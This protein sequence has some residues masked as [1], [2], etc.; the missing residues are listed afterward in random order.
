MRWASR[1]AIRL[2]LVLALITLFTAKPGDAAL[3][4]PKPG[5]AHA[6]YL[7]SHGWHSGLVLPRAVL[8]GAGAGAA[9][10]AV[11]D[12]FRTF[13]MIEFGWGEAEFY[14]ATPTVADLDWGLALKALF[15]PG[16]RAGVVQVVGL[17]AQLRAAFP[18]S[19]IVPL[20][21]S[22]EG[23]ARLLARLDAS[24][25]LADHQPVDAGPS[26]YGTGRFFAANGRF[27]FWNL[28]NHWAADLLNAA[29]L[30][31]APVLATLPRGLIL[32]LGWRSGAAALPLNDVALTK[33]PN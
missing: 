33:T 20:N 16:G 8:T 19:D 6:I 4:P 12:R 17:P 13:P 10:R 21:L 32:D 2:L 31:V 18:T 7:V 9:L 5:D 15:T 24:F 29:G 28:C 27:S 30:P 23:L 22:G 3:Y 25:R 26:L 14:R 1:I 11:A